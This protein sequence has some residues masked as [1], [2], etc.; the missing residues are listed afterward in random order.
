MSKWLK[1]LSLGPRGL[2][3]KRAI[4]FCLMSGFPLL[5]M[6]LLAG[7]YIYPY[8]DWLKPIFPIAQDPMASIKWVTLVIVLTM[9]VSLVGWVVFMEIIAPIITIAR[10]TEIIAKGHIERDVTVKR[11]DEIG[12]LSA[13]INTM[14]S[15]IR[16]NM[17]ELKQFGDRTKELN[18]D[19]HKK[20]LALSNL[21]QVGNL[22]SQKTPMDELMPFAVQKLYQINE[23]DIIALLLMQPDAEH[24][25]PELIVRATAGCPDR[26]TLILQSL[27]TAPLFRQ[28]VQ[29]QTVQLIDQAHP[30]AEAESA[31]VLERLGCTN[32]VLI[33]VTVKG[34][35]F[36]L[37]VCL[38]TLAQRAFQDDY[39]E[40]VKVFAKQVAIASEH[41]F[42][43]KKAEALTV[44]D[45]LTGLYNHKY[46][47]HQ[48]NE[49]I[50][51]SMRYQRP[52]ALVIFDI[53]EFGTL[54]S[55]PVNAEERQA[56]LKGLG[57]LLRQRLSDI[58]RAAR[59]DDDTLAVILPDRNKR[60][61]TQEAEELR[62]EIEALPINTGIFRSKKRLTV[63][64]GVSENPIDGSTA[65]ALLEK[66][67]G[68]L[69]TAKSLG[70]NRVMVA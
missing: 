24:G 21:L 10:E 63:S 54:G 38:N 23:D 48:L 29:S 4:V 22:I 57:A 69:R 27:V 12:D 6:V 37:F 1:N 19:I 16:S 5:V 60:E 18:L 26:Q 33:P 39:L 55:A 2:T 13:A 40:V 67:G 64:A 20:I 28:A 46:L 35:C 70:K 31:S 43:V 45:E 7:L 30:A 53:D 50:K 3:Y 65:D 59:L 41:D 56:A 58:D 68:A 42:L 66:A 25:Q 44:I 32:L 8:T 14:T 47:R 52:C 36:G 9:V 15:R 11:E 51:R 62:K 61:A 49:E 34:K 17:E